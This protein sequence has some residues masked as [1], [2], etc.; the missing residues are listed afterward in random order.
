MEWRLQFPVGAFVEP[1][2]VEEMGTIVD[3]VVMVSG[4]GALL[5]YEWFLK[6]IRLCLVPANLR[7]NAKERK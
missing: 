2:G 5:C 1:A 3:V 7:E 4:S 6:T